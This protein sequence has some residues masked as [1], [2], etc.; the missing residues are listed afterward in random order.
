MVSSFRGED[1]SLHWGKVKN[2]LIFLKGKKSWACLW[3]CITTA[4]QTCDKK[5]VTNFYMGMIKYYSVNTP[6]SPNRY[7]NSPHLFLN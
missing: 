4:K 5:L 6:L 1:I 2:E 3:S 7:G